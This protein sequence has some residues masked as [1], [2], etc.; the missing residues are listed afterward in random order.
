MDLSEKTC[1]ITGAGAGIGAAIAELFLRYGARVIGLEKHRTSLDRAMERIAPSGG[2]FHPI[3]ADVTSEEG[4]KAAFEEIVS[5]HKT[6]DVLVNNVGVEF[7]KDFVAVS[8]EDWEYQLRVNL[9]SVF[10]C[11]SQVV[12]VMMKAGHGSV[13]NTASVQAFATT[14]QTAPY[15]AAK[16]GVLGLTRDLARDLGPHQIR[17]NAICPG[18]ID[19]P[20]MERSLARSGDPSSARQKMQSSIPL[21]RL[22]DPTE[23]A[24]AAAFLASDLASYISGIAL[25]VDGGLLAQL[26]VT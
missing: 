6:I 25:V 11:C 12:P 23:I 19:T 16:A 13:I 3:C 24:N 9:R 5:H 1:V 15:A 22:G 18:C 7:Y 2:S 14:G 10:L 17:V 8:V 4:V 26:P 21:R 20:M